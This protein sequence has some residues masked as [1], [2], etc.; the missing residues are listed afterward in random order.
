MA[1][2]IGQAFGILA[3]VSAILT[4]QLKNK[5]QMLF[6]GIF[7][8][9]AVALNIILVDGFSSGVIINIVAIAQI[10]ISFIHDKKGTNVTLVEKIIF[11]VLYIVG[12]SVGFTKPIDILSIVAAVLYMVAMFQKQP[13]RIRYFLLGNMSAWTVY[14][15]VLQS[16]AIFAQLAG[17][18]SSLIGIYR[19]RKSR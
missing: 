11:L 1:Y 16:T 5:N 9:A 14:F 19:Y 7:S 10:V 3:T 18:T 6:V 15:F 2:Y 8:N 12:G 4:F 17:I 13:Q